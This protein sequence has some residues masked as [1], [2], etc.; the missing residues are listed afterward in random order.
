MEGQSNYYD[1]ILQRY[2]DIIS[3]QFFGHSHKDQF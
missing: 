3:G 2:K 1:Q